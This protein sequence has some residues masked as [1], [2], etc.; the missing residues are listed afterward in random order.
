MAC[1]ADNRYQGCDEL[2]HG[3]FPSVQRCHPRERALGCARHPLHAINESF[4][5]VTTMHLSFEALVRQTFAFDKSR[6]RPHAA[7]RLALRWPTMQEIR[8]KHYQ[9]PMQQ[10]GTDRRIANITRPIRLVHVTS[11]KCRASACFWGLEYPR[12]FLL[13]GQTSVRTCL[14]ARLLG[15]TSIHHV[16][17]YCNPFSSL[18]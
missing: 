8:C 10:A 2:L 6:L 7:D 14:V 15:S 12:T 9:N 11:N 17:T 4:A 18:F 16:S 5:R 1:K 3:S 13:H